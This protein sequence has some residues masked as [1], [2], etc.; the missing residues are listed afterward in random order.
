MLL[1]PDITIVFYSYFMLLQNL[2]WRSSYFR[3]I[4]E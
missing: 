2:L 1:I 3:A 4:P